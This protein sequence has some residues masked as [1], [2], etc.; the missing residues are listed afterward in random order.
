MK[1]IFIPICIFILIILVIIIGFYQYET[2]KLEE[3]N[4]NIEENINKYNELNKEVEQY[5]LLLEDISLITTS[6]D[7]LNLKLNSIKE[8]IRVLKE[9]ISIINDK[10]KQIREMKK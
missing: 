5:K 1:K 9:E 4:K 7:E 2:Y 6:N 3:K 8:E 10:I